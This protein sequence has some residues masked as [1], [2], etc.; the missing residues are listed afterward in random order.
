MSAWITDRLPT[1]EVW[2]PV[3]G[4]E[5]LYECSNYGNVRSVTRRISLSNGGSRLRVGSVLK[6]GFNAK[7]YRQVD[8]S[9]DGTRQKYAVH[10]IVAFAFISQPPTEK[11]QVNHIDGNKVN[12]HISNLEWVTASYNMA[13]AHAT[14]L[15]PRQDG[16]YGSN[17]RLTEEQVLEIRSEYSKGGCTQLELAEKHGVQRTTVWHV[18]NNKTWRTTQAHH[19]QHVL[20]MITEVADGAE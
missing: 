2:L 16:I 12:N 9:K 10:R 8:L 3:V 7:G 13:H 5:G 14:G 18:V 17:A 19:E 11:H 1:R 4:Y 15:F 20:S 6:L